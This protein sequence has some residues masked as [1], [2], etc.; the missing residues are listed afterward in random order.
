MS[1]SSPSRFGPVVVQGRQLACVVCRHGSF[2]E[3]EIDLP[4]PLFSFLSASEWNGVTQCAVCERCGYVHMFVP[5]ATV[6]DESLGTAT[7]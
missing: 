3:Q 7:T 2:W 5:T 1:S 6:R 4:T